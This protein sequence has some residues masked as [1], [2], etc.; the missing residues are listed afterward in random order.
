MPHKL[1]IV[2]SDFH[3][4]KGHF[5]PDGLPNILEDFHYDEKLAELLTYYSRGDGRD[6]ASEVELVINGDFFDYLAVDLDGS[7]PDGMFEDDAVRTTRHICAGHPVAVAA[8]H[9]FAHSDGCIVRYQM[10]NHDPAI[11]WP[12]VQAVIQELLDA[13]VTFGLDDY[14]FDDVRIEHG[15]QREVMHQF[16]QKQLILPAGVMGRP[17]PIINFPFGC[18]FVTQFVNQLRSRRPY[19]GQV[20]PFRLYLRWAYINDFW[21]A[22][23]NMFRVSAF[24]IK[25]R[26]FRHPA[27]YSRFSKTL[28][29]LRDIFSPPRLESIARHVLRDSPFRILIMGHN[30]EAVFRTYEGGKQY[31]NSGTWTEFT[32]FEPTMLGRHVILTYVVLAQDESKPWQVTLKRWQGRHAIEQTVHW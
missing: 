15:H 21:F 12:G 7:R 18:F 6:G 16:D 20:V 9:D 31:V 32:S 5:L 24:F 28:K 3:L 13:P 1:K 22:F 29:I 11:V 4:G 2:I 30:H 8:L 26:F 14:S 10:G 19:I 23:S 25:M 17:A 27:R